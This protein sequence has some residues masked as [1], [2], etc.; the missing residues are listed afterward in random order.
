MNCVSNV[1]GQTAGMVYAHLRSGPIRSRRMDN[2][3]TCRG[4]NR[5]GRPAGGRTDRG[6]ERQYGLGAPTPSGEGGIARIGQTGRGGSTKQVR[7]QTVLT[8]GAGGVRHLFQRRGAK[9]QACLFDAPLDRPLGGAFEPPLAE[10]PSAEGP[11]K[12]APPH[13]SWW[14]SLARILTTDGLVC[15]VRGVKADSQG[16]KPL[17]W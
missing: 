16:S 13:R 8:A 5:C 15:I 4:S 12:P 7:R 6:C 17:C 14:L 9:T 10:G 1:G 2:V 3:K 11:Q